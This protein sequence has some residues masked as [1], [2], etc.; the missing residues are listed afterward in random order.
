MREQLN[1]GFLLA[2]VGIVTHCVKLCLLRLFVLIFVHA[3]DFSIQLAD[4]IYRRWLIV[5]NVSSRYLCLVFGTTLVFDIF[6]DGL[7]L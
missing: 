3:Q 7:P 2:A 4:S 5:I 1:Q 6:E